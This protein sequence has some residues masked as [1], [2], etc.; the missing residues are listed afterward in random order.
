MGLPAGSM[1][2]KVEAACRFVTEA[3]GRAAIGSLSDAADVI[4]GTAGT[5]VRQAD[6]D[7]QGR[8][9]ALRAGLP[10]LRREAGR[11]V[12]WGNDNRTGGATGAYCPHTDL[13]QAG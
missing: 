2:P 11:V 3:G 12:E 13:T 10:A 8:M 4:S 6:R 7:V 9:P 5:Q 1:G